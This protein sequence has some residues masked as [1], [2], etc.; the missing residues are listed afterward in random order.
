LVKGAM[1]AWVWKVGMNKHSTQAFQDR[2]AALS[3]G[4]MP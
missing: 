1:V 3:G 4:G 2:E